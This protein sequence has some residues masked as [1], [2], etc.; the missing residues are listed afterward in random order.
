MKIHYYPG[1]T[2]KEKT[3]N[4]DNSTQAAM[5][6]LGLELVEPANW[7]CCGTEYPLTTQTIA[8]LAA[9]ARILRQVGLEGGTKVVTTC[10]FCFNVLKRTNVDLRTDPLRHKRI[11]A[12]LKDDIHIDPL[13]KI[14]TTDFAAYNG[15]VKVYHLLEYLRDEIGYHKIKSSLKRDLSGLKVAPYYGCRLLRP[16][17]DIGIDNPD[18]PI[19]FEEFL[20]A[21]G[22][23]VV[24]SPFKQECCGSYLSISRP[25]TATEASYQILRS[26]KLMGADVLALSCPLCYY[27]LDKRQDRIKEQHTDFN[28]F[29]VLFF[30][31]ILALALDVAEDVLGLDQHYFDPRPVLGIEPKTEVKR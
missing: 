26:A 12:F 19:I 28:G 30:T 20:L 15:E 23:E 6:E 21:M 9:P 4:L 7:T 5:S 31:Q 2:L 10:A 27:N 29:P 22:C 13:S 8:G 18:D 14:K 11:N 3:T 24:D 25:D 17:G 1:C 16:A